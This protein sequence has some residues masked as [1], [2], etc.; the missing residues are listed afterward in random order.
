[1]EKNQ[2]LETGLFNLN[3]FVGW[4]I[5]VVN[6]YFNDKG[7]QTVE[8]VSDYKWVWVK[9]DIKMSIIAKID[10][11]DDEELGNKVV[12][13]ISAIFGVYSEEQNKK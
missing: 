1:M 5:G 3:E 2:A 9:H 12:N 7:W 10:M 8:C 13:Q 6:K 4:P 11:I